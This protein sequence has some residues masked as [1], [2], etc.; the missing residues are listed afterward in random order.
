MRA[1][2]VLAQGEIFVG[3]VEWSGKGWLRL[4]TDAGQRLINLAHVAV[5]SFDGSVLDQDG[6]AVDAALP[7]PSS[8]DRPVKVSQAP[9]RP[10]H[11]DELK[12][13]ADAFL[14]GHE[15]AE[16][17]ERHKRARPAIKQLRQGFECA[18]GNLV[19]DQ[20][21]PVAATWVPRWRRV[22]AG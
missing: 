19:E 2:V 17:A 9:G 7:K 15:D 14:D 3:E 16:L 21:S 20:I 4:R 8:K 22:L 6:D 13:L 5:I 11:D 10:W 18:R 12:R 1:N